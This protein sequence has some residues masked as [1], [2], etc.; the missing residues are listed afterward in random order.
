[1]IF[2]WETKYQ[3]EK[4]SENNNINNTELTQLKNLFSA[5]EL[6]PFNNAHMKHQGKRELKFSYFD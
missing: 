2:S 4:I 6:Q 5:K 1:M 3:V